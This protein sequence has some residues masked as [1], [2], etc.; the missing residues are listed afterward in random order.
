[1]INQIVFFLQWRHPKINK[2]FDLPIILS[3]TAS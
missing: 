3:E 1:L 2:G